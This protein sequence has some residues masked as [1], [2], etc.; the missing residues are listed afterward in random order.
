[1]GQSGHAAASWRFYESPPG[2]PPT[3]VAV[4]AGA[5]TA[6]IAGT[7]VTVNVPLKPVGFVY[8]VTL[9]MLFD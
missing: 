4:I 7:V 9:D 6:S 3:G 2:T 8:Q 5:D 1:V